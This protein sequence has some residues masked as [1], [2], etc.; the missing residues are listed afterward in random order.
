M[1]ILFCYAAIAQTTA[2]VVLSEQ[3]AA[4]FLDQA[5]W[6]AT[7]ASI[8]EVQ[9]DGFQAWLT[10]QF[11]LN[12]SDLP[13]QAILNDAGKPNKNLA[14][15]QAA[16]FANTV[17]SRDQLRQRIAFILSQ[18]WVVSNSSVSNAYA[19]PP[20]WRIL[21]D[22]AFGN[23]RDIMKAVTLN[24]AMGRYLN[25]ANNNKGNAVKGTSANENYARELLQLFTMGL[26]RLNVDGSPMLDGNHNTIP[27]YDQ[28]AITNVAKILTG[29]T[30]P[31]APG[32]NPRTNN[33]PY[34][35]GQMFA[36]ESQHDTSA[37]TI[38][39][40]IQIPAGLSAEHDLDALLDAILKQ[41]TVAPFVC[42]Q[43]IEHLVTSNPS[44]G[45]IQRV[46]SIFEDNGKGVAGD[47]K[48]VIT[49]IL[50]D[51]EARAGDAPSVSVDTNFGHLREPILL[52]ANLM[53]GLNAHVSANGKL[54]LYAGKLGENLFGEPSVFSYFSPQYRNETGLL[55]PEF[56]IYSTQS[57]ADR[58]D[59]INT[60]LYGRLDK[61]TTV[62]LS[63]FT[64]RAGNVSNLV[65]YLSSVFLHSSMSPALAAAASDA[66]NAAGTSVTARAQA[67]L[68][69]TL[70]S[71]EY[72]VI[73]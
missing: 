60:A 50:T 7:P 48:A 71:G 36:V 8:A 33:P 64:S 70:T 52:I 20:Y 31:T 44:S 73:H 22:N 9:K 61:D 15:V 28:A 65:D 39:S 25:M 69:I 19:Y 3:A 5:T 49:A 67:A 55:G 27:T 40:G 35:I 4:R 41:P 1:A 42:Q 14:P 26:V 29:W 10:R 37:K 34:Y 66:A 13:D 12:T 38:F 62:D 46:S 63:P 32:A 47:M 18:I 23:Y 6:G 51:S 72:Q 16:F 43:L 30:Y 21:R 54:Y 57:V 56:Q 45:Y 2:P 58:M 59:M 24:P 17:N 53:R 11:A 68:Y